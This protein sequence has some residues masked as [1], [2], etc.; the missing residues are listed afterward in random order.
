MGLKSIGESQSPPSSLIQIRFQLL[1]F[2]FNSWH[3]FLHLFCFL[4]CGLSTNAISTAQYLASSKSIFVQSDK[5]TSILD[6]TILLSTSRSMLPEKSLG[7]VFGVLNLDFLEDDC[8]SLKIW[9]KTMLC[10]NNLLCPTQSRCCCHQCYGWPSQ[11]FFEQFFDDIFL[12]SSV[13]VS[14]ILNF[15]TIISLP[16]ALPISNDAY[17]V[18]IHC[19][20]YLMN[21]VRSSRRKGGHSAMRN[22]N[23]IWSVCKSS[24]TSVSGA[25]SG[26]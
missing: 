4:G 24:T 9:F 17:K 8:A 20:E 15:N 16:T 11:Q 12:S 14:I 10:L 21:F 7:V 3:L 13:L 19:W 2:W 5:L 1:N 25:K 22:S 6:A 26:S 18:N 23:W